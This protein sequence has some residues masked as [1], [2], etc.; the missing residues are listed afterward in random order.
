MRAWT[1]ILAVALLVSLPTSL[2]GA[3]AIAVEQPGGTGDGSGSGGPAPADETVTPPEGADPSAPEPAPEEGTPSPAP[4]GEQPGA[5]PRDPA[6]PGA[7]GDADAPRGPDGG[8][9]SD[10][11]GPATARPWDGSGLEALPYAAGRGARIGDDYPARYRSL[12]FPYPAGQYIWDEW[13]FAYR[14]CT[15]FVSWRLNSANGVPFS[16]QYGGVTR[17]GDAGQWAATARGLGIT[18]DTRP[19]VGAVAWSGPNYRGASEFGHVAWVAEV[20]DDGN[21]VIEEYN[22]GWLGAYGY[23]LV[24]PSAFQGYIHVKDLTRPFSKIGS[25]T[26]SGA[27]MVGGTLTAQSSGWSPEPGGLRYRWMRDG[28]T[29]SGATGK[30]YQPVMADL[31]AR[32]S[33]EVTAERP[34]YRAASVSSGASARVTMTDADGDGLEDTQS[35]LPWNSDVNGD[36]LPDAVGMGDGGVYVALNSAKGLGAQRLW[37]ADF[38]SAA[39]WTVRGHPRTLVDVNGDGRADVVGFGDTGVYVATSTGSGFGKASRW[40]AGFGAAGTWSVEHHPRTLA[41]VTGDGLPDVVGFASDGVLVAEGTGKGF[42]TPRLWSSDFG[43]AKGWR[44]DRHPRL[45]VDMNNDG[46]D[47]IVGFSEAGVSV[48]LSTGTGFAPAKLWA[49]DF[50]YGTGWR[51]QSHVR[52]I[53]DVDGDGRPDVVGFGSGGVYVARNTGSGLRATSLW[54]AE[55]GT[56]TGWRVGQHPRVLADVNGD[57]RADVVGFG[58]AGTAVALSTGTSFAAPSDWT[59][60]FSGAQWGAHRQPRVVTDANGDGRADIVGFSDAG[61]RIALSSGRS[62]AASQLA[63]PQM[64][65][66]AGWQVGSHPRALAIRSLGARPTPTVAGEARLGQSLR[67]DAGRWGPSPVAL[68]YQWRRD[69][70]AIAGA[71]GASYRLVA[72]DVGASISVRVTGRKLGHAASARDSAA[73]PVQ[74]GRLSSAEPTVSGVAKPGARLEASAGSWGPAPVTLA[75][76][77]HRNGSA[78]PGATSRS[79]TLSSED[80][81]RRI[82]VTVTGSKAAHET[83]SRASRTV[84]VLGV[85]E[86]PASSPFADVTPRHKFYR[87]IAWMYG[88][89]MSTGIR[90]PSGAPRYGPGDPVSR[91]AMAAFLFRLAA[92]KDGPAPASSPFVDVSTRHKFFREIAWMSS[93]GLSNGNAS[94]AGRAYAPGSAVSREAM[95][96]FLYR[97]ERPEGYRPPAVSPFADVPTSHKF[98]REIAWMHDSGLSTGIRQPSG[99]PRYGPKDAVSREAMAAFLYRLEVSG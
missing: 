99:L 24:H 50:G 11:P 10:S 52:A 95:A 34:G 57:G 13:N 19:E 49:A 78:I 73:Q 64:G 81:G 38:G 14:Q 59:K 41:D 31:G 54:R 65:R 37:L 80:V 72:S 28:A 85:P 76:Q 35:I 47:D 75:Y 63:L 9:A 39:G 29:I 90:Q 68:S 48:A 89:G 44:V 7:P 66:N 53:A 32:I 43:A 96:A 93:S 12:P 1:M 97:L 60:E 33:V 83:T 5:E 21:I 36:G 46:R 79:Y 4:D 74:P 67:A 61:I 86:L 91:E 27:P 8:L 71:T 40:V 22:N 70:Q 17:W 69:G 2:P 16:N 82:T 98:Y 3:P 20:R 15:S 45:L 23:R 26:V 84:K 55:F 94:P 42:G 62:F 92:P 6:D 58:A 87:E 88:S 77:W 30:S 25:A 18:V 51:V 56:A